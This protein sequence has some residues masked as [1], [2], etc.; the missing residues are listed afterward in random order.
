MSD[1]CGIEYMKNWTFLTERTERITRCIRS[2]ESGKE[3][4]TLEESQQNR[5]RKSKKQPTLLSRNSAINRFRDEE[6]GDDLF[7]DLEDFLVE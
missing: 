7:A 4:P 2:T 6:D 1:L 3:A 5:K